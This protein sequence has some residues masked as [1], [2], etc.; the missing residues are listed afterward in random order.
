MVPPLEAG[1]HLTRDEFERRYDATPGIKKAEL[2]EGIV[3]M[4]PPV[5]FDFHGRPHFYL[6]TW[7]TRYASETSGVSGAD[8]SSLRLDMKNEPQPDVFLFIDPG[9]GG[10]ARLSEGYID[11]APE[12]VAE[13]SGSTVSFDLNTKFRVYQR[14]GIREY[15]VWRVQD[16]EIDWFEMQ[17]GKYV[18]M[19][20]DSEGVLRSNIFPGLWLASQAMID[21]DTSKVLE[22]LQRGMATPEHAAFVSRLQSTRAKS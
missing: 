15:L 8:N 1:D 17:D 4:A 7:L 22:V 20:G 3:Y 9:A 11:G 14:N 2:I 12:L 18:R 21:L 5:R 19:V 6:M 13:V 10:L 16:R